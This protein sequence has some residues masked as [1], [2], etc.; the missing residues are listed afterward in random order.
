MNGLHSSKG[1]LYPEKLFI[2]FWLF[3]I[4]GHYLEVVGAYL[5][6]FITGN[7]MWHP[8]TMTHIPLAVPYGLGAAA[9]ILLAGD[10]AKNGKINAL[11]VFAVNLIACSVIEYTCAAILVELYGYNKYWDYSDR[12][13]NINGYICLE[14][15]LAFGVLATLFIYYAHPRLEDK[16]SRMTERQIEFIFAFMFVSYVLDAIITYSNGHY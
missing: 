11:Q 6:H 1:C 12:F 10:L 14:A 7:E 15:S 3:S 13:L 9:A 2:Y 16:L 4:L 8:A 5:T